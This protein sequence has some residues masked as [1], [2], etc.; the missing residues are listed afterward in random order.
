MS[1]PIL[2]RVTCHDLASGSPLPFPPALV[3]D[4]D[5]AVGGLPDDGGHYGASLGA[6]A[7]RTYIPT[8]LII[9]LGSG[10]VFAAVVEIVRAFAGRHHTR[11]VTFECGDTK[12]AIKTD[13]KREAEALFTQLLAAA[14]RLRTKKSESP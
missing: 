13:D 9:A 12:I 6:R 1:E 5:A 14:E 2:I 11:E 3:G 10:G 7:L 8:E 4:I